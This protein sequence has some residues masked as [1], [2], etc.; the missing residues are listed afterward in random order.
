LEKAEIAGFNSWEYESYERSLREFRDMKG[1]IDTAFDEGKMEGKIEGKIEG[2][3]EGRKEIA[4][5]M[6]AENVPMEIMMRY[7][8]LSEDEIKALSQ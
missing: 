2:I 1:Y 6:F 3:L 5:Q 8:G 4:K 7:T